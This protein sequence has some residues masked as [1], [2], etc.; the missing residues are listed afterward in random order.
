[1]SYLLV[2]ALTIVEIWGDFSL[3]FFAQASHWYTLTQ[4]IVAYGGVVGLLIALFKQQNVLYVNALWDGGS[5]LLESL[6]AYWILGDRF[7]HWYN[8]LG[9]GLIIVGLFLTAFKN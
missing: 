7:T 9:L 4:G 6:A 5:A 1:M 2:F 8:Y 3:R